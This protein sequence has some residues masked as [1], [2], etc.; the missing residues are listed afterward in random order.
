MAEELSSEAMLE[1]VSKDH[2]ASQGQETTPEV[3]SE[4]QEGAPAPTPSLHKYTTAGGKEVEEPLEMILKRAGMGYHYAQQMHQFNQNMEAWNKEKGTMTE[5]MKQLERWEQYNKYAEENPDWASYVEQNWQNRSNLNPAQQ[6]DPYADRFKQYD[7][8]LENFKRFMDESLTERQKT[9][10]AQEDQTF[11][12]EVETVGK[13][14]GVDFHQA[15]EQGRS[16]EWR[17]LDHM[18]K[19]GMTGKPGQFTAAYK[20]FDFENLQGK[21]KQTALENTSKEKAELKKAGIIDISRS[22]KSPNPSTRYS[23]NDSWEDLGA[24]ALAELRQHKA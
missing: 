21:A 10:Y 18:G 13:T 7:E 23:Q 17:V 16:L 6:Q 22:P 1:A 11:A 4:N 3:T 12:K 15:D 9:Q 14:Y 8:T 24:K 2:Q 5:R 19:L 20:D